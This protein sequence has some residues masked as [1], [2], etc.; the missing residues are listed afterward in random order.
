MKEI[1]KYIIN[2]T[3]SFPT[4]ETIKYNNQNYENCFES[5]YDE[6]ILMEYL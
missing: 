5:N 4:L 6:V 3:I 1:N 2:F